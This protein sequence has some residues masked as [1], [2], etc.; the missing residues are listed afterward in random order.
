MSRISEATEEKFKEQLDSIYKIMLRQFSKLRDGKV[1]P[2]AT[3]VRDSIKEA[4]TKHGEMIKL[5]DEI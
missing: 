2:F 5:Q 4:E 1:K 3:L